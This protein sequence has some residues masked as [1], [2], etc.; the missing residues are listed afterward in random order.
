MGV[1]GGVRAHTAGAYD[2]AGY[3]SYSSS[4]YSRGVGSGRGVAGRE[5]RG[6][7]LR[8]WLSRS[9]PGGARGRSAGTLYVVGVCGEICTSEHLTAYTDR[10]HGVFS[11]AA[12][13]FPSAA[14]VSSGNVGA[15]TAGARGGR[16]SAGPATTTLVEVGAL[17]GGPSG[18]LVRAGGRIDVIRGPLVSPRRMWWVYVSGCAPV[19]T[20]AHT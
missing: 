2:R 15:R 6:A 11:P 19:H 3:G 12:H 13:G 9:G 20:P 17:G 5:Q 10:I 1:W 8:G 16:A 14:S 18:V 7:V 4:R